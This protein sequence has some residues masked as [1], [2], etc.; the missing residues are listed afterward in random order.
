MLGPAHTI[1]I[2]GNATSVR[3]AA[4]TVY[5]DADHEIWTAGGYHDVSAQTDTLINPVRIVKRDH[6][7][8]VRE[9][10]A[11]TRSS[12]SGKLLPTDSFPQSSYVRWTTFQYTDCCLLSGQRVYHTIPSSGSG[13]P[14]TNYDETTY[15]YDSMRRRNRTV[16]PGGTIRFDVFD[17]RNQLV[18]SYAGTDDTGATESDPTGGGAS[19]NDMVLMVAMQYDGG[20]DGGDG[21]LTRQTEHVDASTTRVTDYAYD[22]RNRQTETDGELDFFEKRVYDNLDRVTRVD[23]HDTNGSGNLVSR[24]DTAFDNRGY[25]Y[26]TT[27]HAVDRDTGNVTGQQV[28]DFTYDISGNL[29]HQEPAG[30]MDEQSLEYDSLGR[31]TKQTDPLNH[32][33]S[34]SYDDAGN[35]VTATDPEN[36]DWTRGYDALGRLARSTNPLDE[37]TTYGFD[38][39]GDQTTVTNPLSETTMTSFDAAGRRVK[40]TDPPGKETTYTYDADGNVTSVTDPNDLTTDFEYDFLNRQIKVTDPLGRSTESASNRVG[41]L[42]VE[43]DAK[44]HD[45]THTYDALG[46]KASTTDRLSHTTTFAW[47]VLGLLESLTD[48]QSQTTSYVYDDYGRLYQT[49]WPD[50]ATNTQPGDQNYGIT[51]IE[52]DGLNRTLRTTDQ[53][54][55]T[56]THDYD[57]AGRLTSRDYRTRA[58]SPSGTISDSDTFTYDDASR[59]LTAVSGRYSN[60]VTHTY[61]AAGRKSSESLTISGQTYTCDTEY[62]AAGRVSK[63]TY[64]DGTEV[65]RGYTDRG[66]LET[67]KVDATTVDTRG[68]DDGG[69]MTSSSYDNGVSESR[70]YNDDNTLDSITYSGAAIGD[71]SYGWAVNRNKT[72]ETIGGVMSGYGFTASYDD[73]DRLTGWDRADTNLDQSWDLSAVGNWDEF[74]ENATTQTRTHSAADEILT[75]DSENVDHDPKGNTTFL[76]SSLRPTAS[77]LT[78]DFDNKLSSADIDDDGT[79]DV[80]Y[81]WDALGRRVG[82]D[83]G[84]NDVVYFQVGQQTFADY[85]AGTAPSSPTYNYV[86]GSYIDEI[87]LRTGS[88][89]NRFYHRNG[90]YSITALTNASGT[91]TERYSYTAYGQPAF[92]DGSGTAISASA[93]GNRFCYTGR[94]WDD[95]LGLYHYRAACMTP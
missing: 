61:D 56:V 13:S 34:W 33:R 57:A 53:L 17:V 3:R 82:R 5:Q 71:L 89:G 42:V 90:Q 39:A 80:F 59:M 87:I 20:S 94:E 84:T 43:T 22:W 37:S 8:N 88:G 48:A 78:W 83:D 86:Y 10:I 75:V 47:N 30:T 9:T 62:D 81:R 28:E 95:G 69:R 14:G 12:T 68:Y 60:T 26:R 41:E 18:E 85:P 79:D 15:G 19:G 54:G 74:I 70:S 1:D 4:W 58:N 16:A 77:R 21:N 27:H 2:G 36:E 44:D 11:A 32:S 67:V 51:Q 46:R 66:E 55:D 49:V 92:F 93:E 45:T 35:L 52:Y 29:V 6:Q 73:E 38:D 23:R 91:I 50:H 63:L 40:V 7:G 25:V 64:P 31:R 24:H 65:E 76:P 72:S